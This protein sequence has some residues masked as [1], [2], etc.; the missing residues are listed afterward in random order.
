M[1]RYSDWTAQGHQ[2]LLGH[3]PP[4]TSSSMC[5]PQRTGDAISRRARSP[6]SGGD[7]FVLAT[8][9]STRPMP[10]NRCRTSSRPACGPRRVR[11]SPAPSVSVSPQGLPTSTHCRPPGCRRPSRSGEP[12][13]PVEASRFFH[14][15]HGGQRRNCATIFELHLRRYEGR[16][17]P[18]VYLPEVDHGPAI[19]GTEAAGWWQQSHLVAAG[20]RA[21]PHPCGRIHQPLQANYMGAAE[22]A[23][24]FSEWQSAV[25]WGHDALLHINRLQLDSW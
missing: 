8:R 20:H 24:N 9:I 14:R 16:P 21:A 22:S 1:R 3:A 17:S 2:R 18:L 11:R 4:V 25:V 10:P 13:T 23:M 19:V 5:S 12:N 15:G 6:D 7:E